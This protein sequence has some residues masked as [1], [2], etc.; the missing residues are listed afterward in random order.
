MFGASPLKKRS[1]CGGKGGCIQH[2]GATG[3]RRDSTGGIGATGGGGL[4]RLGSSLS[5]LR[6]L[7]VGFRIPGRTGRRHSVDS[8]DLSPITPMYTIPETAESIFNYGGGEVGYILVIY[9]SFIHYL[10]TILFI[11]ST[12]WEQREAVFLIRNT[13]LQS[14]SF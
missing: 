10:F 1:G 6:K 7:S 13:Q 11:Y 9:L 5:P 14:V 12:M 8:A 3:G 4:Q 2:T